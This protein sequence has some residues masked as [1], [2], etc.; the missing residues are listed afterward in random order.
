ME[1]RN[2]ALEFITAVVVC[3]AALLMRSAFVPHPV[4]TVVAG[5]LVLT[6]TA[7]LL[8][9]VL[10]RDGGGLSTRRLV[11]VTALM[12]GLAIGSAALFW[13]VYCSCY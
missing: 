9:K 12:M 8:F 3:L 4:I 6:V 1:P 7:V 11:A 13:G 2:L 5:I 10:S